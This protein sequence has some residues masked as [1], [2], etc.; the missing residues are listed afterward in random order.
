[1]N[2]NIN[3]NKYWIGYLTG[4]IICLNLF[5][6]GVILGY[7]FSLNWYY[8]FWIWLITLLYLF[9]INYLKNKQEKIIK[10]GEK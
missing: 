9:P 8:F 1:M 3:I 5:S 10:K 2:M 4:I 7:S 6:V